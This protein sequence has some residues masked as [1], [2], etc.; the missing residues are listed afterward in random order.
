MQNYSHR[1]I[2]NSIYPDVDPTQSFP[3]T[4]GERLSLA[5]SVGVFMFGGVS[6]S[7]LIA[8]IGLAFV[9]ACSFALS[10]KAPRRIR[11]EARSRFP[12]EPWAEQPSL[13]VPAVWAIIAVIA[14]LAWWFTPVKY[15]MWS[16]GT[17]AVIAATATWFLPTVQRRRSRAAHAKQDA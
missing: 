2:F 14:P 6:G 13:L 4:I 15:L 1:D 5:L 9:V 12:R 11:T 7:L 16:A 3:L 17:M 10:Q 8:G